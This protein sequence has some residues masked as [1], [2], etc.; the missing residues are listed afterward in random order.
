MPTISTPSKIAATKGYGAHV[1]FSGSTEDEREKVVAEVQAQTGAILVPP[2]N[3]PDIM[4]GQGTMALEFESQV[5]EMMKVE[6][7]GN[8]TNHLLG[9]KRGLNAVITPCGGGG[10]LSGVATALHGTGIHVFGAEPNVDGTDDCVRGLQGGERVTHVT[11]LTIA[12]GLRTPVAP[13]PWTI[14]SDPSKVR[15]VYGVSEEQI[16]SAMKL[17]MERMKVFIEPSAAVGLATILY[18]EDF[19]R[20]AEH[21][22]GEGGWNIGVVLSGGNTTMEAIGKLFETDGEKAQREEGVLGARG[23]RVAENVNG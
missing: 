3:H 1:T 4:L 12:D 9:S 21:E 22:A 13:V 6:E 5:E 7:K 2:C 16:R 20:L 15:A 17:V 8:G 19:R 14:I 11:T 10:M 18:N 23:E